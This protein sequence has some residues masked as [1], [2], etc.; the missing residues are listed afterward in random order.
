M[1]VEHTVTLPIIS[2]NVINLYCNSSQ[3]SSLAHVTS[4]A[5]YSKD[6]GMPKRTSPS[7][8]NAVIDAA[9][10]EDLVHDKREDWRASNSKAR[11]R[12][13]RYKNL[14]TRQLQKLDPGNL[15]TDETDE[16]A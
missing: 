6:A 3:A 14:L 13:R 7:D 15:A 1:L 16:F 4:Q 10:L 9:D 11:R 8:A 2:L 12:D 5:I